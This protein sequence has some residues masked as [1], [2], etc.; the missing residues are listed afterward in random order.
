M[1]RVVEMQKL[2]KDCFT[3]RDNCTYDIVRILGT[4]AF[5][6]YNGIMI[7]HSVQSCTS[8]DAI[9]Y[10]SGTSI[11]IGVISAGLTLKY[12]SEK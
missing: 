11:L 7:T 3:E 5:A 12:K 4:I 8:F 2:L 9:S 10:A 6:V 1:L